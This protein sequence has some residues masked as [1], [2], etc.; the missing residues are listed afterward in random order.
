MSPR[1]AARPGRTP[2]AIEIR[3][4]GLLPFSRPPEPRSCQPSLAALP[5]CQAS[6]IATRLS[7]RR[8]LHRMPHWFEK[9][10]PRHRHQPRPVALL[11]V[12]D[13]LEIVAF[14]WCA[15]STARPASTRTRTLGVQVFC[16]TKGEGTAGRPAFA[17]CRAVSRASGHRSP[18]ERLLVRGFVLVPLQ[19]LIEA[20]QQ[21]WSVGGLDQEANCPG[22][23]RAIRTNTLALAELPPRSASPARY[24][25]SIFR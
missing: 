10:I 16:L 15:R 4:H 2:Q 5:D 21:G 9:L 12:A 14:T 1:R 20:F 19:S 17:L 3:Q 22:L 13:G 8:R 25:G 6:V 24:F 7:I 23:Q 18:T 11:A